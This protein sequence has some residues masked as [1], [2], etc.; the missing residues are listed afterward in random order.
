MAQ[1]HGSMAHGS[2]LM[3]QGSH[4]SWLCSSRC[5]SRGTAGMGP[6]RTCCAEAL[7]ETIQ[8]LS[9]SDQN[10]T[11]VVKHEVYCSCYDSIWEFI[12]IS[13]IYGIYYKF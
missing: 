1:G 11:D 7:I 5:G 13:G 12:V 3:A 9:G 8:L 6:G 2:W 10:Q 4:S